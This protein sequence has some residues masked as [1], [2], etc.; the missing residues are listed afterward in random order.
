[1]FREF[2]VTAFSVSS[3]ADFVLVFFSYDEFFHIYFNKIA[4]INFSKAEFKFKTN[5]S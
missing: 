5:L 2:C 1:M 3:C 4:A